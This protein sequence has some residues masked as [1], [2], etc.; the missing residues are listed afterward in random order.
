MILFLILIIF[1][2]YLMYKICKE[3]IFME[4]FVLEKKDYF[5]D[6][7]PY[8]WLYWDNVDDTKPTPAY[9]QLCYDTVVKNCSQSF[10]IVRLNKD[11]IKNYLPELKDYEK[12]LENLIIAHK[13]DFYRILL[14]HKYGGIYMDS[15]VIVLKDPIEI[16]KKLYDNEFVG[17]G[18]TGNICNYGYGKPSNW[19]LAARPNSILMKNVLDNLIKRLEYLYEKKGHNNIHYHE[20]GKLIIWMELDKLIKN[21]KYTY[22]HYPNKIDGTRDKN[23]NWI[24]NNSFFS[25]ENIDYEEPEKMLFII[26][27]NSEIS[28]N[29]KNMS[30]DDLL[31]LDCN[32]TD[33]IKKA[34]KIN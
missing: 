29:I 3:F 12:Y 7:H 21:H 16:I 24:Y 32:Y 8:L 23:G 1:L 25:N 22:F 17:F 19:I 34:L 4:D 15:D 9:I 26:L 5:K 27:Y 6:K 31:N 18:C 30:K 10:E 2:F 28:N 20:L 11:S 14:L 13:V 33:F